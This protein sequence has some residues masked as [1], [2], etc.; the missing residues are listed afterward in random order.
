MQ[1]W[2]QRP[3]RNWGSRPQALL[4]SE[5]TH[6][7]L[8]N[9]S[10]GHRVTRRPTRVRHQH[11]EACPTYCRW[12]LRVRVHA[13]GLAGAP[14]DVDYT[15][16]VRLRLAVSGQASAAPP[17]LTGRSVTC[18]P[19]EFVGASPVHQTAPAGL[20]RPRRRHGV[21]GLADDQGP[22]TPGARREHTGRGCSVTVEP[23]PGRPGPQER[24]R[25]GSS[26]RP[27]RGL[28]SVPRRPTPSCAGVTGSIGVTRPAA[29][30]ATLSWG[31]GSAAR[32]VEASHQPGHRDGALE[33]RLGR[34]SGLGWVV[35]LWGSG[36]QV[37]RQRAPV[38]DHV[39]AQER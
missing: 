1:R 16:A 2:L 6:A 12:P 35:N 7:L 37:L 19:S 31:P 27:P 11:G 10:R 23:V 28:P 20:S 30:S 4:S 5:T 26:N 21:A 34:R 22:R 15:R 3:P 25:A 14:L 18:S 29:A 33:A 8:V 17:L 32:P 38:T 36:R 39:A 9:R 24:P 13:P